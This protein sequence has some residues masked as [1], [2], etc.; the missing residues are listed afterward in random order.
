MKRLL[1]IKL[2]CLVT[3]IL[4]RVIAVAQDMNG[5]WKGSNIT[6]GSATNPIVLNL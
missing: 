1:M 2:I 3:T 6:T 5:S 4:C